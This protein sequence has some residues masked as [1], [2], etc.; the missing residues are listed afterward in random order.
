MLIKINQSLNCGEFALIKVHPDTCAI[1]D[2]WNFENLSQ[3]TWHL[4][5]Q[6]GRRYAARKVTT[7]GK[8]HWVR[9]HRQIM[10]TKKGD[11]VHHNNRRGLDNREANMVNMPDQV[12]NDHHKYHLI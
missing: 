4:I 2:P 9:M 7:N 8:T 5:K 6:R 1:V 10:H 11:V 12:H 3:Y